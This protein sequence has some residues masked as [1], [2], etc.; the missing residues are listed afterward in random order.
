VEYK[1]FTKEAEKLFDSKEYLKS[2]QHYSKAFKVYGW[3]GSATDRYKAAKAW[4]LA[5]QP[6]SAFYSLEKLVYNLWFSE[7]DKLT[8]DTVFNP[9]HNDSRWK[10]L[11]EQT[12]LN[13]LPKGWLR[14]GSKPQSYKMLIDSVSDPGKKTFTIISKEKDI[15]GFGTLMQGFAADKYRGKRIRMT[16]YM[17]S[18][19]VKEWAGF[20]LRVDPKKGQSVAFDNMFNRAIKGTTD[21]TKYEIVLDV[22]NEAYK[23]FFGALLSNSGQI[24]FDRMDFEI[25]DHSVPT[26]GKGNNDEPNLDFDN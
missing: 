8:T 7:Y 17:K 21:W 18:K 13:K 11:L 26:T 19:D 16:G 1:S 20:W 23:I 25:V 10:P 5:K 22:P 12:K 9:L 4:T 15:D 14:R 24:W 3:K 6:D 2:A